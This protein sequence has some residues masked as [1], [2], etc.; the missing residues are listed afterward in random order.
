MRRSESDTAP[1]EDPKPCEPTFARSAVAACAAAAIAVGWLGL[2]VVREPPARH[3]QRRWTSDGPTT[4][5]AAAGP[6]WPHGQPG[7]TTPGRTT[8]SV[9]GLDA[10]RETA[11]PTRL[12]ADGAPARVTLPS[13]REIDALTFNGRVPGPELRVRQG[14][15]VEV[16]LRNRDVETACRST[17]TASTCPN[18]EDGVSGVTQDAVPPGGRHV[19]R[20]RAEQAGT[21]W[22]HTH[23]SSSEDG[24]ARALRRLRHRAA[25]AARAGRARPAVIPHR[26]GATTDAERPAT[27]SWRQAVPPGTP[28]RLRL[29]NTDSTRQRVAVGPA[30]FRVLAIDGTDLNEP[31]AARRP[32]ARARPAAAAT[33][34]ASAMPPGRS[35]SAWRAPRTRLV[36]SPQGDTLGTVRPRGAGSTRPRTGSPPRRRSTPASHFDRASASR[37]AASSASS[38]AGPAWHWTINGGIFPDVPMFVVEEGDLVARRSRTTRTPIHPMHLHGHHMLV[39]SRNGRPVTGSPWWIGHARRRPATSATRSPSAPTTL[40][41]GWI[42]ATT[43]GT[44]PPG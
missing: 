9:S 44:R 4:A 34:S 40:A 38:T 43:S 39:L 8:F 24:E 15:L 22:Y 42:T 26:F 20:F 17:G 1:S 21:F 41:S 19:Y 13:G 32:H 7:T 36:L 14:D 18:A 25:R 3:V 29:V 35:T 12:H 28:V 16:T 6:R 31:D 33:T 30:P 27:A 11:S 23:Q 37:S 2:A 5:A 10:A